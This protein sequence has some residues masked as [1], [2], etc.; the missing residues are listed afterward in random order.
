[1]F[2]VQKRIIPRTTETMSDLV[3]IVRG[4]VNYNSALE[5]TRDVETG[6][7]ACFIGTTRNSFESRSVVHLEY[8]V[9]TQMALTVMRRL[10]ATL[11]SSWPGIKHISISH[12]SGIVSAGEASVVIAI[13]S[14]H[15]K[16]ALQAV[17]FAIEHIKAELPVWK[18]EV[19]GDSD[20]EWKSNALDQMHSQTHSEN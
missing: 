12:A 6:A 5:C 16:D 3:S 8:D 9:Y 1:M 7:I 4:P 20:S 14:V 2:L 13:S 17:D 10:C 18:K 15:R 11:R 19:Y